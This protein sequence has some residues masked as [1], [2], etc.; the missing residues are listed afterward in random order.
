[1][2]SLSD[3]LLDANERFSPSEV[4]RLFEE[5]GE[6]YGWHR[7]PN[8]PPKEI[9]MQTESITIPGYEQL[10]L[11]VVRPRTNRDQLVNIPNLVDRLLEGNFNPS[12]DTLI[13]LRLIALA[14]TVIVSPPG[15]VDRILEGNEIG[16]MFFV[17]FANE[18]AAWSEQRLNEVAEKKSGK[19][20]GKKQ[21]ST[22]VTVATS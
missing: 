15:F 5:L 18:Y 11:I 16:A 6:Q 7:S 9:V 10:G 17:A 4:G 20:S 8:L 3:R 2:S 13:N 21:A 1:M 12:Q 19:G 14:Q 22:S